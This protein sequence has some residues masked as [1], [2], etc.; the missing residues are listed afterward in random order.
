MFCLNN[1]GNQKT[2][3]TIQR[4]I[5]EEEAA[6]NEQSETLSVWTCQWW[7]IGA[8]HGHLQFTVLYRPDKEW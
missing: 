5:G 6:N 3:G 4:Q 2:D 1:Q 8:Y 7:P